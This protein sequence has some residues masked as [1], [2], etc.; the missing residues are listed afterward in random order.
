MHIYISYE[1]YVL[2]FLNRILLINYKKPFKVGSVE[3]VLV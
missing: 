2:V 1:T 3:S